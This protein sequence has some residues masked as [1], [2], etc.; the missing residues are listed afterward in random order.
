MTEYTLE[1]SR[2]NTH[3]FFSRELMPVLT[4][5]SG[6][7]VIFKTLNAGWHLDPDSATGEWSHEQHVPW[8]EPDTDR[9]HALNGPIFIRRAKPGM[10]LEIS[11]EEVVPGP[12]GWTIGGGFTTDLNSRL[13]IADGVPVADM[14]SLDLETRRAS[15]RDGFVVPMRPFLGVMGMPPDEPGKHGTG[16]PRISGGNIDC[17]ELV[18]G[19]RL[20]LPISVPGGL[21]S[22]GDG[23]AVQAD[24]EVSGVAIECPMEKVRLKLSLL[25]DITLATPRAWTPDEWITFGFDAD[26]DVA[27]ANALDGM[28]N[29]MSEHHGMDRK[30]AVGLAS[31]V[32]DLRITQVVNGVKGV[33]AVLPH[34]ALRTAS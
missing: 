8:Y 7:I 11:I 32:V 24:G 27:M 21:L 15:S 23:H 25:R 29:L 17:K 5:D 18:A 10:T 19:T 2:H 3:G 6:D 30:R 13:G 12:W 28:L 4:I 22:A 1:A 31:L 33:H 14:W 9:G 16:P 34:G 26:L 20:L